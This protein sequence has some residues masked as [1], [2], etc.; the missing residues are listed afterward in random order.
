VPFGTGTERKFIF[1]YNLKDH[2][3]N[4]RVTFMGTDLGG[5]VDIVQTTSYYPFGLVMKQY[6]GNTATGFNKNKYLYNGK[7]IQDDKMISEA[8]NWYDFG[9]R[10]LTFGRVIP[11]AKLENLF[12]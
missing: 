10:F 12:Q 1:E 5:A 6:N 2:L 9:K 4:S 11:K 8:L 7:E 3:G